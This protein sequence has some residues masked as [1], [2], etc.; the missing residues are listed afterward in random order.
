MNKGYKFLRKEHT[1]R[2]TNLSKENSNN[3]LI[4]K[5]KFEYLEK[6]LNSI[7]NLIKD[8][9]SSI[10]RFNS[11]EDDLDIEEEIPKGVSVS[12]L[13]IILGF[14][15]LLNFVCIVYYIML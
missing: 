12:F 3:D 11:Y 13:N 14:S 4:V 8:N 6:R 10:E 2:S 5:H 7:E 9:N 1:N 15:I